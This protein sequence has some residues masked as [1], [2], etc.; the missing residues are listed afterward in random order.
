[1]KKLS[2]LIA[3]ACIIQ[4]TALSQSCLPEG[5][6]F[7]VQQ[8]IDSFQNNYPNCTKIE[9]DV[10]II[11]LGIKNLLGLNSLVGIGGDITIVNA[12]SLTNL[13]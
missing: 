8:Q 7:V 13:A 3:L 6:R 5:I 9:G 10:Q 2:L 12:D 4:A 11:G 1:M